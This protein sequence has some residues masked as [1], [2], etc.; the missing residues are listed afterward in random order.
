MQSAVLK[1]YRGFGRTKAAWCLFCLVMC[2]GITV[3]A[4]GS[5]A[6]LALFWSAVLLYILLPGAA[7]A[8]VLGLNRT[9]PRFREPLAILL[10]TGILVCLYCVSIRLSVLWLARIVPLVPALFCLVLWVRRGMHRPAFLYRAWFSPNRELL[11]LLACTLILLSGFAAAVKYALPSRAGDVLIDQDLLWLV[12][13]AKSFQIA[14]PPQEIRFYN[15]RLAYHYLTELLCASL[16]GVTGIDCYPMLAFYMQPA[17][18]LALVVCLYRFG[19]LFY[20]DKPLKTILF[21]FSF[22][23]FGCASLWAILPNGESLFGNSNITHLLTNITSQA[24]AVLYLCIFCGLWIDAARKAFRVSWLHLGVIVCAFVMLTVAKG[25]VGGIVLLGI[26]ASMPFLFLQKQTGLK[27]L[28]LTAA[29]IGAFAVLY[30]A[31]FSASTNGGITLDLTGSV[32]RTPLAALLRYFDRGGYLAAQCGAPLFWILQLI[33]MA[34]AVFIPWLAGLWAD[35]RFWRLS[36]ERLLANACAAGGILA[37]FLFSHPHFSQVYFFFLGLFFLHLLAV[38]AVPRIV[39]APRFVRA[40]A[41]ILAAIALI[42]AGFYYIH[43]FGSGARCFLRDVGVLEKYPYD[44]V[45][46]ADDEAAALWLRDNT[47]ASVTRFATNR[48][49]SDNLH[50]DGISNVYTALS[51]R[52]AIME[53]YT[54]VADTAPWMWVEERKA[55]NAALFSADSSPELILELCRIHDVTHLVYSSQMKQGSE[56]QLQFLECVFTSPTVR[57]YAVPQ[58]N[59]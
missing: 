53:G 23:L 37:F 48:I 22:F 5:F 4:G 31:L 18:L 55:H 29:L 13:N 58:E 9:M 59:P 14:F 20:G 54:Y 28:L 46:N 21:P 19:L 42:T 2:A 17:M 45:I 10:G 50:N 1:L 25:P 26:I 51:G 43:V 49:H 7:A 32:R 8:E 27:G 30:M 56:S 15:V 41:A 52:Q 24:T 47:D 57:I 44:C 33:C 12:G 39:S 35:R 38:D 6:E 34:P 36:A 16:S 40:A 3:W 11:A